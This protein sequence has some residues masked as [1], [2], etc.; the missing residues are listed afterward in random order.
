MSTSAI[1]VFKITII[2]LMLN[3]K[4]HQLRSQLDTDIFPNQGKPTY[5]FEHPLTQK[6]DS[7]LKAKQYKQAI[8]LFERAKSEFANHDNK[9]GQAY[10]L[11]QLSECYYRIDRYNPETL[12]IALE[13][14]VDMKK[15]LSLEHFLTSK[16]HYLIMKIYHFSLRPI[17]A[18]AHVDTAYHIYKSGQHYDSLFNK[19]LIRFKF[20]AN[21]YNTVGYGADTALKYLDIRK[22]LLLNS[23]NRGSSNWFTL[24]EDYSVLYNKL[25]DYE[26]ATAI[27][28]NII[29]EYHEFLQPHFEKH[30]SE[31]LF[32]MSKGYYYQKKYELSKNIM[33]EVLK[34]E[35]KKKQPDTTQVADYLGIIS[36]CYDQ[37]KSYD[38]ALVYSKMGLDVLHRLIKQNPTKLNYV[39][40]YWENIGNQGGI[41]GNMK[42]FDKAE[43]LLTRSLNTLK[44]KFP[45]DI[46]SIAHKYR[47]L[48]F[49]YKNVGAHEKAVLY[50]DSAV[51]NTLNLEQEKTIVSERM[52]M[53]FGEKTVQMLEVFKS[54]RNHSLLAKLLIESELLFQKSLVQRSN[55]QGTENQITLGKESKRYFEAA[56][57]ASLELNEISSDIE[58]LSEA[59][60]NFNRGKSL[61]FLDQ[62]GDFSL[63]SNEHIPAEIRK[64]YAEAKINIDLLDDRINQLIKKSVLN[65]SIRFLNLERMEW[66]KKLSEVKAIIDQDYGDQIRKDLEN[67]V[68]LASIRADH[69]L[70]EN[71]AFIEFFV[72]DS[73]IFVLGAT[74]TKASFHKIRRDSAFDQT[75]NRFLE[76]VNNKPQTAQLN[77]HLIEFEKHAIMLYQKLMAPV[78]A[79]LG[80][81]V[82]TLI[83]VPDEELYKIPFELLVKGKSNSMSSFKDMDFLLKSYQITHALNARASNIKRPEPARGTLGFG[84]AGEGVVDERAALGGL[85]GAL[86][87]I[88]YLKKNFRGDYYIGES[89]TKQQFL[90]KAGEYEVLHLALH[91]KADSTS[92]FNSSLI[93]NGD[94][95]YLLTATDLYKVRLKSKLVVLS[96]CETG[97]GKIN[98]GEGVFSIARGFAAAGIP[99]LVTTL[100]KVNDQAGA[101]ITQ[102]FYENL[103]TGVGKDVALRMAKL[104]YL[105]SAD[106]LSSSPYYWGNYI[107][108]GDSSPINI[109]QKKNQTLTYIA[110]LLLTAMAIS[111]AKR[112]TI[113]YKVMRT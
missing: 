88:D 96:A 113:V 32:Q 41:Y 52:F 66:N 34:R 109:K 36:L 33:T 59:L 102:A 89:G 86:K 71:K 23:G 83:I 46:A 87:E 84:Y 95:D 69:E 76:E 111:V 99:S 56:I 72:G 27:S 20:Y 30:Y 64:Q 103:K 31:A 98:K 74:D 54:S 12:S 42:V 75:V 91:G 49:H 18:A 100:W 105:A 3:L 43:R 80:D 1:S 24:L 57:E 68:T 60:T 5:S 29:Q 55:F 78:L 104:D 50:L 11:L 101:Q 94:Q 81:Q 21:L 77:Q 53:A 82:N 65:D 92:R 79:D 61:L 97:L 44:A 14:V 4:P 10:T 107:L 58:H 67:K 45:N 13:G 85:P 51:Q 48:G 110:I 40:S 16:M 15:L 112:K 63:I 2:L 37:L 7:L 70:S 73:S 108:L 26:K 106:N 8:P 19:D 6:A 90:E 93:F 47:T 28:S 9:E 35:I 25:G 38:S 62:L 22:S 39:R 17:K